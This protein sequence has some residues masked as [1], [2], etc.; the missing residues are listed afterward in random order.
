MTVALAQYIKDGLIHLQD[1]HTYKLISEAKVLQD[2]VALRLA[3]RG[4]M[5]KHVRV[6]PK[7]VRPYLETK[8]QESN[9][10]PFGCFYILYKLHKN[11]VK[12]RPVCLDCTSPPH[13]LREWVEEMLQPI[14]KGQAAYFKDSF[15]LKK[16]L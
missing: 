12:S 6:L 3:I 13:A 14:V 5:R 11:P 15:K 1:E 7:N 16:R 2:D 8:L 10:E 9:K 4:W